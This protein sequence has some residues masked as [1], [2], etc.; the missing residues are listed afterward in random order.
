M[1]KVVVY[2][3]LKEGYRNHYLIAPYILKTETG[4]VYDFALIDCGFYPAAIKCPGTGIYVEVFTL[5]NHETA[6]NLLD[7][8]EGVPHLYSREEVDAHLDTGEIVSAWIYFME[9][10]PVGRKKIHNGSWER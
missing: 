10:A 3:T 5:R 8:L 4:I 9:S 2:G 6:L 7:Q 1:N